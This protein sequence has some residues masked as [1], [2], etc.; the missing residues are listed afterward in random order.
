MDRILDMSRT[1]INV[2]GDLVASVLMERWVG[3]RQPVELALADQARR[4]LIREHRGEDTLI[5]N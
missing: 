1:T 3:G 5:G 2:A 4:E